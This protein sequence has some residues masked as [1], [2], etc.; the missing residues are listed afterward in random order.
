M[1]EYI[2]WR[3]A[4]V[5]ADGLHGQ[6]GDEKLQPSWRPSELWTGRPDGRPCRELNWGC[7]I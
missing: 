4:T 3:R 5:I 7:W 2:L 1:N 6:D